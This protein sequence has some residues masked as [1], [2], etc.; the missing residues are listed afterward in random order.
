MFKKFIEDDT[1]KNRDIRNIFRLIQKHGPISKAELSEMSKM[2][3]TTL[4]RMIDEL[5]KANFIKEHGVG[6]SGGGRP[7]VL[8]HVEPNLG[9]LISVFISRMYTSIGLYN[10]HYQSIE[11]INFVMT[12][13]H[14]PE[15]V[16]NEI[17][18]CIKSFMIKH[19]FSEKEL[20]GIGI[21]AI[22]PLDSQKG[23]ILCP[24]PF[25]APGWADVPIVDYLKK[26]FDVK[27]LLE[28][29]SNTSVLGEFSECSDHTN[30]ILYCIN[31]WGIGCGVIAD[32]KLFCGKTGDA[33]GYGHIIIQVN[34]HTCTCGKRGCLLAYT[35][36]YSIMNELSDRYP[37]INWGMQEAGRLST[38]EITNRLIEDL[39]ASS[40]VVLNSAYYY[41]IGVANMA[42]LYHSD[43]VILSGPLI[44][45]YPKYY[46]TVVETAQEYVGS[47]KV[48][49]SQGALGEEAGMVGGAVM[50]FESHFK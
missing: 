29:G 47:N 28:D 1:P 24:D 39:W 21:G 13:H 25:F 34:G 32:G 2:K 48:I 18:Q 40:D 19:H 33:S 35:S 49:F 10:L 14:T 46:E 9:Y 44:Y 50:V 41:G 20:L 11:K 45:R 23:M 31:G 36:L 4:A 26:V 5:H 22:G 8:F 27:I 38:I 12:P 7:P 15:F 16:L 42:K 43:L 37:A 17:V 6:D 3:L 30:N